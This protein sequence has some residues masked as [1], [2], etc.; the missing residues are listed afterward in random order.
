MQPDLSISRRGALKATGGALGAAIVGGAGL[1]AMTGG[2]AAQASI[3][4]S[5]D[6][7][8]IS[9]DRG[10][11]D[12]VGLDLNKAVT[13]DGFD[14]PVHYIGFKHEITLSDGGD[15]DW[16]QLYPA[17]G[18]WAV[19]DHMVESEWWDSY[20]SDDE[21]VV[22]YETDVND[23]PRGTKGTAE[24]GFTWEVIN[25]G[26]WHDYGYPTGGPQVPAQWADKLS[27]PGDDAGTKTTTVKFRTTLRF[28]TDDDG[29]PTTKDPQLIEEDDGM[30]EIQGMDTFDVTV[31]N[32][33]GTLSG[34]ETGSSTSG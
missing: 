28:Y 22:N 14:I 30:P 1:T 7:T 13:W 12:Y 27:V 10:E 26:T 32:E 19:S 15:T 34:S 4:V 3:D 2:A 8:A 29:D 25:D 18:N 23:K 11:L 31:T 24:M 17:D 20:G 9:N 33:T 6:D 16:H 5:I 21:Q